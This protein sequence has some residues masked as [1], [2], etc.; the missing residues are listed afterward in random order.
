[1]TELPAGRWEGHDADSLAARWGARRVLLYEVVGSTNDVARRVASDGGPLPV[2]VLADEQRAGRG[3]A[4]RVWS[5]PPGMGLWVSVVVEAPA[6]ADL[7]RLPV[8]VGLYIAEAL[9]PLLPGCEAA[10]KWPNDLWLSGAKLGGILCEA[11]WAGSRARPVVIGA[12]LNLLQTADDFPPGVRHSA[13][14][15]AIA[16]GRQPS[17]LEVA[18]RVVRAVLEAGAAVGPLPTPRL[19]QRDPLH[20]RRLRISDPVTGRSL[21]EGVGEGIGEDGALRL[22]TESGVKGVR[23]GTVRLLEET[24]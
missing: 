19:R 5:S 14:S 8:R 16:S 2:V 22:R 7:D 23:S 17:R 21:E 9:D 20:G 1:M 6:P 18:D 12:G 24:S 3:R 4:G 11:S 15:I 13:T 10:I